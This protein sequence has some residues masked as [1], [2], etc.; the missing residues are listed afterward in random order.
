MALEGKYCPRNYSE[1]E[2]DLATAIY[3]LGGGAAL[4]AL[5][6]SPFAFPS[7]TTLLDRR[8]D[9]R[10]Q[11][12]VG[13][14]MMVDLL[15]NI[16][17]MFKDIKPG[18][19][20]VGIT[21]SMDEVA[22]DGRLCYLTETDDIAGLC[23]HA[24]ELL[25]VKMGNNLDVVRNIARAVK[26]GLVHIGQEVFVAAFARNDET[27]YGAKPVLLLPT[28]KQGS[29]RDSALIIEMLRQAWRLSPYGESLHGPIWSIA[30][31]G[32]PKCR[33]ALYL[34]CMVREL[35]P[36]QPLFRHVGMLPGLNLWTGSGGE[37]QDLDYKHNF[38][39]E[40]FIISFSS[41]FS[42]FSPGI[43]KCLCAREGILID[44]VVINKGLL[45]LWL[46]RLTDVDW[47][48]NSIYSLLSPESFILQH[49]H[50]LLSPKDAQDV[51]RAIKLLKLS[52]DV[53]NL[54]PTDFDPSERSTHRSLSLLG[55]ML[56]A[57]VEPF[58]NPEL[59]ISQQITSLVKFC[60]IACALFLKHESGF[61]PHHLYSDLQ[62]MVRTAIFRVAHTKNLDP[63][64]KVFLCLL[65]D[66]VLEVV[67]GRSRM[68]GGHSPNCDV[69][70]LRT[71]FGSALRLDG[72]FQDYPDWEHRP[73]RLKM[74]R[75]RD[76]DHLS[77][78]H[79]KGELCAATCDLVACW[80][81][82]V[83]Q[84]EVILKKFGYSI[85]FKEL[86]RDWRTRSVDLMRPAGG[87]YPGISL[88][89]DRS[90]GEADEGQEEIDMDYRGFE[91]FDGKA[92][93]EA[94][95]RNIALQTQ[96]HLTWM[97]LTGGKPGH[98]KTILRIFTDPTLGVDYHKS[99]DRLLRVRYF[100]IGGDNW[101][102]SKAQM[103]QS[104]SQ[105]LFKLEAL[106][107]TIIS[108]EQN[109]V[110]L[111]I[112]RCTSLKLAGR[113]LDR[114]PI[115][116]I[117]LPNSTYDVSGQILSLIPVFQ[118][119]G[120]L[121]WMWDS[122]FLALDSAKSCSKQTTMPM[123]DRI[124]H[125]N[126]P[127]NRSLVY[128]LLPSQLTSIL[129]GDIPSDVDGGTNMEKTWIIKD[130]VMQDIKNC[131]IQCLLEDVELRSKIPIFGRARKGLFPYWVIN[132]N[133]PYSLTLS[134]VFL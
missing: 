36:D 46:E 132:P 62:C 129:A 24:S 79:W 82:G 81:D 128:P 39:R 32:D 42:D 47:S 57:L 30:S 31:D 65:G 113:H 97:E 100:S 112:L 26:E 40:L 2:L 87:K 10:L 18:H 66:D 43:C 16:E 76:A 134:R 131:L 85:S 52:A 126:I 80:E 53:R 58:I 74:T 67:F 122:Q 125:L 124:Q 29:F 110:S 44:G 63:N 118:G 107:A 121:S 93:L 56:E 105:S 70:E 8:C 20:K 25:S 50:T 95:R 72:I 4:H 69:D 1:L 116:E 117:S 21:L 90:L 34:H 99:H 3:E 96:T 19:K 41:Q 78:R 64:L 11:I 38:K 68:I 23:E 14:I 60:H 83:S 73:S 114:A 92:A 127:V 37:T 54:D 12:S 106:Y 111:A 61:M 98:K 48:E 59:S 94:E 101:D 102:R 45:A 103:H 120:S 115:E 88:E 22:S 130:P 17:M 89:V 77:P 109:R 15:A 84:A 75:S 133:G 91:S 13:S 28:C 5:H 104:S 123:I 9:F 51:P 35:T 108:T 33:P 6:N 49:I 119:D 27:D 71:R 7:R 55:E 86:F